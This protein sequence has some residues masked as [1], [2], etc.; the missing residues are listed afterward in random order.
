[1]FARVLSSGKQDRVTFSSGD[2][3]FSEGRPENSS[4]VCSKSSF[5]AE[6][7]CE[8]S[9]FPGPSIFFRTIEAVCPCHLVSN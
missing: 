8:L 1:M 6:T 4:E 7:D 2:L 5:R 9:E 3:T